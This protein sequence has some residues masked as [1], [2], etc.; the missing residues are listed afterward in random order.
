MIIKMW[1]VITQS[2]LLLIFKCALY[3]TNLVTNAPLHENYFRVSKIEDNTII[4][5]TAETA[6]INSCALQEIIY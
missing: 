5:V 6:F 1:E 4:Y 3:A 2:I